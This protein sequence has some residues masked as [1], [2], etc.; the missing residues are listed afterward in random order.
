MSELGRLNPIR[1]QGANVISAGARNPIPQSFDRHDLPADTIIITNDKFGNKERFRLEATKKISEVAKT[2]ASAEQR[3]GMIIKIRFSL[4]LSLLT[5]FALG[6]ISKNNKVYSELMGD[7]LCPHT[8]TTVNRTTF[9]KLKWKTNVG[10]VS[11]GSNGTDSIKDDQILSVRCFSASEGSDLSA[12]EWVHLVQSWVI[13]YTPFFGVI[14]LMSTVII[15]V[16]LRYLDSEIRITRRTQVENEM[17]LRS[18]NSKDKRRDEMADWVLSRAAE[19]FGLSDPLP[20]LKLPHPSSLV[21]WISNIDAE[22]G[23][24]KNVFERLKDLPDES[25]DCNLVIDGMAIRKQILPV[26]DGKLVGYCDFGMALKWR[27]I[28]QGREEES[29]SSTE[30]DS[31]QSS[32]E[33]ENSDNRIDQGTTTDRMGTTGDKFSQHSVPPLGRQHD[34]DTSFEIINS[35]EQ[36]SNAEERSSNETSSN[37]MDRRGG[38]NS[39]RQLRENLIRAFQT[40]NPK[41]RVLHCVYPRNPN[42]SMDRK[43]Y[44]FHERDTDRQTNAQGP[45]IAIVAQHGDHFHAVHDCTYTS[46]QCR[47]AFTRMCET[48]CGTRLKRRIIRSIEY[49]TNHWVNTI[50]YLQTHPRSIDYLQINGGGTSNR[51]LHTEVRSLSAQCAAQTQTGMVERR[52]HKTRTPDFI[53][54]AGVETST[55][56]AYDNGTSHARQTATTREGCKGDSTVRQQRGL[57]LHGRRIGGETRRTTVVPMSQ[58]R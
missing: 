4:V 40:R 24:L 47:C 52:G 58:R 31:A 14:F 43:L 56:T 8:V 57:L 34:A 12:M 5:L 13:I 46:G 33:E 29:N 50:C 9:L 49:N 32:E 3:R 55:R 27:R 7:I 15:V 17:I 54:C 20:L 18:I 21:I 28:K 41:N 23:F 53:Q 38:G 16:Y 10:Y 30:T 22:P 25:K 51:R 1:G 35:F 37:E 26:K 11:D 36:G 48:I 44:D 6:M 39:R 45:T 19:A 2:L 42:G